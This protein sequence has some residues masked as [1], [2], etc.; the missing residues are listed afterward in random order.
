MWRSFSL[1]MRTGDTATSNTIGDVDSI[2]FVYR[3]RFI[4]EIAVDD[5]VDPTPSDKQLWEKT[6]KVYLTQQKPR[7]FRK[8]S[9]SAKSVGL[10]GLQYGK[11]VPNEMYAQ[12]IERAG[13]FLN[14]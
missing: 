3:G 11:R 8:R 10:T 6:R 13:G 12:I 2:L 7:L 14:D 9:V 1:R 4:G 5:V